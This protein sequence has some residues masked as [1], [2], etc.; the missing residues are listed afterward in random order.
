MGDYHH[1]YLNT[2]D[3]LLA[4][5]FEKFIV[6]CLEYYGLDPGHYFSSPGLCCDAMF[7]MNKIQLEFISS[8]DAYL[9]VE[10]EMR[11]G[12]SYIAK[13]YSRANNKSMKSYD[14]NN[15]S[16]YIKYLDAKNLYSQTMR[17]YLPYGRFKW[18]NQNEIDGLVKIVLIDIYQKLTFSILMNFITFIMIIY[19]L[20]KKLK[21]LMICCQIIIKKTA[22]RI[23]IEVGGVK[24][25]LS[26]LGNINKYVVLYRNLQ[27]QL[28]LGMKLTKVHRVL[29]RKQSDW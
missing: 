21:L 10:K 19:Q 1:L 3:L 29:K 26:N 12:I 20:Q 9:F 24:N 18:L 16:K 4:D 8:I 14:P 25:L 2:D 22:D 13:R 6:T 5:D 11:G 17:K 27:W 7:K 23:G 28:S 15:P